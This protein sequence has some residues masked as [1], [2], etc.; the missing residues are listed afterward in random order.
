MKK[1][2][3]TQ[4]KVALVDDSDFE[5]V[6]QHKWH[7]LKD[8]NTFYARSYNKSI[9]GISQYIWM[10]RLILGI[11]NPKIQVD[12][13]DRDGLNNQRDNIRPSSYRQNRANGRKN[14]NGTSKYL[15]VSWKAQNQKWVSQIVANG[16][17]KYLGYFDNEIEAAKIYNIAAK[18][19]HK[20]FANL[21]KI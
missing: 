20:E 5:L 19:Y 13:K 12:H 11:T 14:I 9:N 7:A 4:N 6:N 2:Q 15:G 3:L 10:H 21:N 18:L 8:G 17:K 16:K 1:I